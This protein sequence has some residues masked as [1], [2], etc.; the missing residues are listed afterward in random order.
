MK[1][2]YQLNSNDIRNIIADHY[3]V[4]PCNVKITEARTIPEEAFA[5]MLSPKEK[6]AV[7]IEVTTGELPYDAE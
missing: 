2:I 1:K 5:H 4:A 6:Y 7:Q 3:N